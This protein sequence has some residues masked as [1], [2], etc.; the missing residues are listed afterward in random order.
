M[1]GIF[2]PESKTIE[3]LFG[4][5]SSYYK[6]PVYQRPYTWEEEHVDDL[7]TDIYTAFENNQDDSDLDKNYF[8]GSVILTPNDDGIFNIIDG[9]QRMT[10][11]I[12]LFCVLRDRLK[13][14]KNIDFKEIEIEDI[15]ESIIK[16]KKIRV[17]LNTH[18]K[19]Q[20]EFQ[21]N[22]L[23]Q[24]KYPKKF[25]KKDA[26]E[27]KYMNTAII[28][29]KKID[30]LMDSN[31]PIG[32]FLDYLFKNVRIITIT[33]SSQNFAIK[34]FQT[35]NARGMDL[36]PADLIK[37]HLMGNLDI[38][39]HDLFL[40]NWIAIEEIAKRLDENI[41]D[42][43]N[44]YQY[45]LLGK[46]LKKSMYDILVDKFKN[47]DPITIVHNLK[48]FADSYEEVMNEKKIS[49]YS[50][51]Y[52]RHQVY[53]KI[54]LTTAKYLEYDNYDELITLIRNHYYKYWIAGYTSQKIKIMS[55]TLITMVKNKDSIETIKKVLADKEKSNSVNSYIND[56]LFDWCYG[57]AWS[58][59][60]LILLE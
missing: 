49:I 40:Q 1:E 37:S 26:M 13:E 58:K 22:I 20:V 53:W 45:Y 43:L 23:K 36:S 3:E 25:T 24:V 18:M 38:D 31:F 10:T 12:I 42:I 7:W 19:N 34:L 44:Y 33:C 52:L 29:K 30:E 16:R 14:E 27:N 39:Q 56:N 2:K 50:L 57:E 9:Q 5:K 11:L 28:F 4:D 32:N 46:N 6:M 55:F 48:T 8:L 51:M 60:L 35:L 21:E 41:G 54:I 59:P 17:T 15:E 47:Q